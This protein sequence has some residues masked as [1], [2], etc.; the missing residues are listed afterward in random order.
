M[1]QNDLVFNEERDIQ[2]VDQFGFIDLAECL[3]NGEVPT[4]IDGEDVSY[5]GIEDPSAILGK[6]DDIF[7]LYRMNDY[8]QSVTPTEGAPSDEE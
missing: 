8:V 3:A 7:S 5:N 6:P 2:E 1:K 4:L